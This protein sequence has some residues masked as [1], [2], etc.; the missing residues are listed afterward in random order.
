MW[1]GQQG[2]GL[3]STHTLSL[4]PVGFSP[5]RVSE[6]QCST[7]DLKGCQSAGNPTL[8]PEGGEGPLATGT[9]LGISLPKAKSSNSG[10]RK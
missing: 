5:A 8:W 2:R 6:Q 7:L 9:S 1:A 3:L 4:P 10:L